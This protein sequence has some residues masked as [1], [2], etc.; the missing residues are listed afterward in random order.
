MVERVEQVTNKWDKR[1]VVQPYHLFFVIVDGHVIAFAFCLRVKNNFKIHI[2]EK[3]H[4]DIFLFLFLNETFK[5]ITTTTNTIVIK[6][7]LMSMFVAT[8]Y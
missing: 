4:F 6:V 5:I 2:F 3:F 1:T 7:E 8:A